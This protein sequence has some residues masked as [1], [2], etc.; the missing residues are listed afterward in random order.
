MHKVKS[1]KSS[2]LFPA[3]GELLQNNQ[4]VRIT[5]T[6]NSMMPF[7]REN[8]DSVELSSAVI[9]DLHFGQVALIRR[10][11]GVYI[12]HRV[13]LKVKGS[14]YLA[15]DAQCWVEGPLLPEQLIAVVTNI[16]RK[17]KQVSS[18]NILWQIL[19]FL[20]WIRL[21]VRFI[22]AK[23]LKFLNRLFKALRGG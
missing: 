16:W 21:P 3:I 12:L 19:S 7:L 13:I 14:F 2:E 9:E 17:D 4:N 18:S 6:G 11:D 5:V 15:G 1:V 20:W 8:I 22:L 10:N 23:P